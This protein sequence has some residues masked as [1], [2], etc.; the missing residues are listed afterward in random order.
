MARA[1]AAP[2]V[3]EHAPS[4]AGLYAY[5]RGVEW[6]GFEFHLGVDTFAGV[7][8]THGGEANVWLMQPASVAR[9]LLR[10]GGGRA[11]AWQRALER[12]V[13]GLAERVR[14]GTLTSSV[15]GAVGLPNHVRQATGAGWALVGDA[16]YHRDPITGHGMTDAFRDAELLA[17]A[18]HE[19]LLEPGR[20]VEAMAEYD[21]RRRSALEPSFRLAR[22]LGAFPRPDRFTE[23]Q[24][25]LSRVLEAEALELA[26][27]PVPGGTP[28]AVC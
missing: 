27:M 3:E 14:A 19:A 15:R 2:V 7:F 11:Q 1:F 28:L 16:A 20:A 12:T 24:R 25:E 9:D 21:W 13:P 18:A 22:E 10:A 26:S 23:L 5:V 8:P 17:T 4:G 6:D